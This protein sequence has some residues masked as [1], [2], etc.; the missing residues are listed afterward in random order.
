M[1]HIPSHDIFQELLR[2]PHLVRLTSSLGETDGE[3]TLILKCH[4]LLLKYI[5]QGCRLSLLVH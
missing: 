5:I 1:V 2:T 3:L 4:S